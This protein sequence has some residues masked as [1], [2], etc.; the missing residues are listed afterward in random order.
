MYDTA[1]LYDIN[2]ISQQRSQD[3]LLMEEL[4]EHEVE[5][6]KDI[7]MYVPSTDEPLQACW[8]C[9][10]QNRDLYGAKLSMRRAA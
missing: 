8:K 2:E 4:H 7:S 5:C 9:Y 1:D 6:A 10:F 3:S